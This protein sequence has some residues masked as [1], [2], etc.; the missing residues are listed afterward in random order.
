MRKK[1]P[2]DDR[3]TAPAEDSTSRETEKPEIEKIPADKPEIGRESS[4]SKDQQ[5]RSYYYDD[6]HGY[7]IYDP[8]KD[9]MDEDED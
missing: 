2:D 9:D 5:E 6:S 4:W 8:D 3:T 1:Q 7:E